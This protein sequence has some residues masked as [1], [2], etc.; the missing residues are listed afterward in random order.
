MTAEL[1]E[2]IFKEAVVAFWDTRA[3][4]R[5]EQEL[6]GVTDQGSRGAVSGGG[7]MAGF[8]TT[9]AEHL[10]RAGVPQSAVHVRKGVTPLP[11]YYRPTKQWDIVVVHKGALLAAIELKSQVGSFGNNFNNR[12]EEAVG[13]ASDLWVAY[14]EGAFGNQPA[15][16]LGWLMVLESAP[17]SRAPIRVDEP[18]F[19]VLPEFHGTS[20]AKR[21]EILCRKLVLERQYSAAC[22]LLTAREQAKDPVNYVEP[23]DDLSGRGFLR[24]LLNHVS[25]L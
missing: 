10:A 5:Q 14:R 15:P 24:G 17:R 23:A 1:I 16:W 3:R 7:Q 22:L 8:I 2:P 21:Y 4:Q 13:T 9:I 11:G 20:Y 19:S 25:N 6:R 18:H 12:T